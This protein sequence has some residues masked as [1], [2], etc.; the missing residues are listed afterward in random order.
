MNRATPYDADRFTDADRV[1]VTTAMQRAV[2]G[3]RTSASGYTPRWANVDIL[4][5]IGASA[6]GCSADD[7]REIEETWIRREAVDLLG[8]NDPPE[9]MNDE[10]CTAGGWAKSR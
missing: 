2:A 6:I 3:W 4:E 10:G 8:L 5:R 1:A 7:L 9:S